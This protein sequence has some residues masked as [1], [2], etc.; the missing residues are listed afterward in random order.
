MW[1]QLAAKTAFTARVKV[2]PCDWVAAA[3]HLRTADKKLAPLIDAHGVPTWKPTRNPLESLGRA[4][5][6]QQL[7]GAA[8]GTIYKRFLA[9]F[10]NKFPA[11]AT[12]AQAP[13]ETLR[14]A[15]LSN[16][17]VLAL[18]DLARHV[19]DGRVQTSKLAHLND[20]EVLTS[21]LPVRGIGPWSV[22]MFLIFA[23]SRPDVLAT[24]DLGVQK[25][26]QRVYRLRALPSPEVMRKRAAPWQPFRSLG[27]WLMWRALETEKA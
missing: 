19:A 20:G 10:D 12:L 17:K 22:D 11:A 21:L 2:P 6:Y 26:M 4:I 5:V 14:G 25:G 7:S 9:L 16:A 13:H 18:L 15:G 1:L 27:T 8:A 24:G 23:L 3:K